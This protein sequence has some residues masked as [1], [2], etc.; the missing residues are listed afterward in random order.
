MLYTVHQF[1]DL[2]ICKTCFS[3]FAY[4]KSRN[5]SFLSHLCD[6]SI[7]KICDRCVI[8]DSHSFSSP[9]EIKMASSMDIKTPLLMS[10]QGAV[11]LMVKYSY[12]STLGDPK[13]KDSS[14]RLLKRPKTRLYSSAALKTI[15]QTPRSIAIESS[16]IAGMKLSTSLN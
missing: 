4:W 6:S 14:T 2:S 5:P 16:W 9:F 12:S 8:S 15:I 11:G 3:H 1:K 13:E 7:P 10:Y